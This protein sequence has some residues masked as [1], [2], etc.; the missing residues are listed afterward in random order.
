MDLGTVESKLSGGKYDSFESFRNDVQLVIDNCTAYND[1][2]SDVYKQA[3]KL[4]KA[5]DKEIAKMKGSSTS[6]PG[7]SIAGTPA[8]PPTSAPPSTAKSK[9]PTGEER[10]RF[11]KI[12]FQ[13]RAI[14]VGKIVEML[15]ELC[16]NA[17]ERAGKDEIDINVDVIDAATYR[18]L[19]AF[20][21]DCSLKD[22][23]NNQ[24]TST[25]SKKKRAKIDGG[26]DDDDEQNDS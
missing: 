4:Q 6:T 10:D 3:T 26:S 2:K 16:P 19:E 22:S 1:N 15:D 17:I 23:A 14:D 20:A 13:L 12:I 11:C 25:Q 9:V 24:T 18:K 8:P 21:K 7:P 5:F